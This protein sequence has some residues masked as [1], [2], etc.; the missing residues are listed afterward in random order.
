FGVARVLEDAVD[1]APA[2]AGTL[3]ITHYYASPARRAGA[4]PTTADDI[5]S[6]GFLLSELLNRSGRVE[7]DLRSICAR[8][9]AENAEARYASIDALD[10]DI[11]RWLNGV[12]VR[13]HG[14]AWGYVT[15]RFLA[16]H[17]VGAVAAAAAVLLLAGAAVAMA[18]MYVRAER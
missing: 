6:L 5:Y 8:A 16:R 11:E 4:A 18:F 2:Q 7:A 15:G 17:R 10:A 13:A 9:T 3:G 14:R 12:P 1:A